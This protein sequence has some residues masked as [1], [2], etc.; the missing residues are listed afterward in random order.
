MASAANTGWDLDLPDD[1]DLY[2]DFEEDDLDEG[3]SY[4]QRRGCFDGMHFDST[5]VCRCFPGMFFS[6]TGR[7]A[8]RRGRTRSRLGAPPEPAH[9]G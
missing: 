9:I 8:A 2:G 1:A 6:N 4:M 5:Q 3:N 7:T